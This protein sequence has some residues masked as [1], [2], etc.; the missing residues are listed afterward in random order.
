MLK[1]GTLG[2]QTQVSTHG[3][4][5]PLTSDKDDLLSAAHAHGIGDCADERGIEQTVHRVD[6]QLGALGYCR[7]REDA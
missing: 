2:Q 7:G 6:D 5:D 4:Q 1:G 3:P